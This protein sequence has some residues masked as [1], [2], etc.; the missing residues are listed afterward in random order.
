M[1]QMRPA[2]ELK[3]DLA[4]AMKDGTYDAG[5][6]INPR[7]FKS[8]RRDPT[9][10]ALLHEEF[11]VYGRKI[12]LQSMLNKL[13]TTHIKRGIVRYPSLNFHT[14]SMAEIIS[15]MK[16]LN[17]PQDGDGGL[18]HM[19][20]KLKDHVTQR[21]IATW[22]DHASILSSGHLLLTVKF[23]Y[24]KRFF[25]T[26]NETAANLDVQAIVE[27]PQVYIFAKCCDTVADKLTYSETRLE[28]IK[29][30]HLGTKDD[31]RDVV[32]QNK[33]RFSTGDHPA[34]NVEAGQNV[35]GNIPCN[36]CCAKAVDFTDLEKCFR[37]P[38]RSLEERRAL[39]S[40]HN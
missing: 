24:D 7:K 18:E 1:P 33:L 32:V 13:L 4:D 11:E 28:D 16:F 9:S 3:K 36:G 26:S 27:E 34:L 6:L 17:I 31:S 25:L 40:L 30:L 39:V 10:G 29:E 5:E 23:L 20:E 37:S 35:G 22:I 14:I 15:L 21:H 8:W 2:A 12:H 19:R 38:Y